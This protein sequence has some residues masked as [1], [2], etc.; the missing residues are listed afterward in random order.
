MISSPFLENVLPA[1]VWSTIL[2]IDTKH[3]HAKSSSAQLLGGLPW[4]PR[5]PLYPSKKPIK[6]CMF[7]TFSLF[8]PTKPAHR[9]HSRY[10]WK[11]APHP[12]RKHIFA[13]RAKGK[14][15]KK[16]LFRLLGASRC[17][18]V[19]SG[20]QS[21]FA[22]I[23]ANMCIICTWAPLVASFG[24]LMLQSHWIFTIVYFSPL[25][26]LSFFKSISFFPV[27]FMKKCPPPM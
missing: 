3:V 17:L 24:G 20:P 27:V 15:Y 23:V 8:G 9:G 12:H 7:L 4:A 16:T 21:R 6:T 14:F 10:F 18:P 5:G 25:H 13:N 19:A 1:Y 22:K 2:E 26:F 11:S